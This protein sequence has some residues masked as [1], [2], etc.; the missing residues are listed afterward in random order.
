LVTTTARPYGIARQIAE[1]A[2]GQDHAHKRYCTGLRT[3]A[4]RT[5][6]IDTLNLARTVT[7]SW[8]ARR[9]PRHLLGEDRDTGRDP[10]VPPVAPRPRRAPVLPLVGAVAARSP[11]AAVRTTAHATVLPQDR[12][13]VPH[14]ER[15]QP[16]RPKLAQRRGIAPLLGEGTEEPQYLEAAPGK[17]GSGLS[18]DSMLAVPLSGRQI[19][20]IPSC[21][22][23]SNIS[24]SW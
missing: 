10:S 11:S 13:L 9:C 16:Y 14:A 1:A 22:I 8:A 12:E 4:H 19:K 5:S 21:E 7:T 2:T 15:R 24:L 20:L 17:T 3:S 6:D 23:I 18:G